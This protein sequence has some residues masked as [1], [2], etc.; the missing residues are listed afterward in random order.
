[1][2][3]LTKAKEMGAYQA[4]LGFL[5]CVSRKISSSGKGVELIKD[6]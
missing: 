5:A 4:F 1:M 3:P 6:K 2:G